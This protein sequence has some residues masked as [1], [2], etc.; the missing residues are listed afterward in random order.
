MGDTKRDSEVVRMRKEGMS[1][2]D[3]C[4][5]FGISRSRVGQITA[6]SK[7]QEQQRERSHQIL[8]AL[9]STN[10]IDRKWPKE[11]IMECLCLAIKEAFSKREYP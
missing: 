4:E 6:A 11:I 1:L 10:N 5:R 3:I 8:Q 2:K 7:L 9:R